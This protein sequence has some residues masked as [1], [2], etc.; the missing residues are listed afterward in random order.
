MSIKR[1]SKSKY[2][3]NT[4]LDKRP[5]VFYDSEFS[6]LDY[7]H[8]IME[9][10]CVV[11]SPKDLKIIK[12]WKVRVKP[13]HIE[14]ADKNALN[15]FG[16]SEN[17]WKNAISLKE[18][19]KEFDKIAK[20][21]VIIGFN[22]NI[23]FMFLRKAYFE[24]GLKPSFH[25]QVLDV[26]PM[27]FVLLRNKGLKGFRMTELVRILGIRQRKWHDALEDAMATF[28]IYKKLLKIRGNG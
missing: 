3:E 18:A 26:L 14:N 7:N 11:V 12:K 27:A 6:G 23:D 21:S 19:I 1:P 13:A 25:W 5:L 20:N 22:S 2:D 9:I 15:I 28:D 10:G 8:E 16:Y 4:R 17:K 24:C